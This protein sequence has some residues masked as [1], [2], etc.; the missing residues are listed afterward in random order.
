MKSPTR[1]Y[2]GASASGFFEIR[3]NSDFF[4][5]LSNVLNEFCGTK[6]KKPEHLLLLV[7][8]LAHLREWI[9]SNYKRGTEPSTSAERFASMLFENPDYQTILL[10]ANHAKHQRLTRLPETQTTSFIES[11]DDRDTPIDSWIDFDDGPASAYSYGERD[12]E[13]LFLTVAA[14]YRQ[15][16]FNLPLE[17][18]MEHDV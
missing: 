12:L 14:L 11:F 10:L 8:G 17:Q 16:W 6:A 15:H 13:Q 3:D 7:L 18:R 9:A 2:S 1:R 5:L 4:A